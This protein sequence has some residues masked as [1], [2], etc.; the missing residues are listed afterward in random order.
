MYVEIKGKVVLDTFL[1]FADINIYINFLFGKEFLQYLLTYKC[2][3]LQWPIFE[4]TYNFLL[5]KSIKS[6]NP[7][8]AHIY[9]DDILILENTG[10]F[11]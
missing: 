7:T 1:D 3:R 8:I 9:K 5:R 2:V 10:K 6:N 4:R 11:S